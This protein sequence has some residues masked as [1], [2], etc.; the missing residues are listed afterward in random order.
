MLATLRSLFYFEWTLLL[1]RS[2]EWLYPLGFFAIVI[3]LFPL[4]FTPDP[5]FLQKYV[6][7]CIWI[8][9]LLASLLSVEHI[10]AADL[11]EAYLEQMVLSQIPLSLLLLTK[12][13]AQWLITQLP[14]I[15]LTPIIGIFF[16]LPFATVWTLCIGLLLGTPV[17]MLI[18]SLGTAL[19]LGLRQQGVLL[20]L[21]MLPLVTPILIFG[22]SL[23][24]QSQAGL[25]IAGP[26]SFLAGIFFLSV[27]LL[28]LTIAA[29]IKISL[30]N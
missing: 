1:R 14:L 18:G 30:D 8:A 12:F 15:L 24:Q 4:A 10:F 23:V 29:T 19:T 16:H 3:T 25:P 9:A 13:A 27:T 21:L 7:G 5:A 2:Q 20:S 26:L 28:P 11:E 17:L 6:P 22:V